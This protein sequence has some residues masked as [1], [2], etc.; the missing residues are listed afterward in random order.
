MIDFLTSEGVLEKDFDTN[1]IKVHGEPPSFMGRQ[2]SALISFDDVCPEVNLFDKYHG[3]F[4]A[5]GVACIDGDWDSFRNEPKHR[6]NECRHFSECPE[7]IKFQYEK[8][9]RTKEPNNSAVSE[10]EIAGIR[11]LIIE[12]ELE[13]ALQKAFD[14][15]TSRKIASQTKNC[16]N[17]LR[18]FREIRSQQIKGLLPNEEMTRVKNVIVDSLLDV[19]EILEK[20]SNDDSLVPQNPI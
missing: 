17:L 10:N 4:F 11:K 2:G 16:I 9:Y 19:L 20:G 14:F 7:F 6:I 12:D 15:S 8:N 3:I 5:K 13:S 18:R 1:K